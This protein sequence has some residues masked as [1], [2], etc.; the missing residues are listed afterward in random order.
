MIEVKKPVISVENAIKIYRRGKIDVPALRGLT[1]SFRAGD[2]NVIMGPSG[3]GKTTLMNSIAGITKLN[4][5]SIH[6]KDNNIQEFTESQMDHY[7]TNDIGYIFQDNNLFPNLTAYENILL[8]IYISNRN[9]KEKIA[10]IAELLQRLHMT[11]RVHHYPDELSGGEE[12]RIS[13]IMALANNPAILLCDEPTGELDS[14]AKQDVLDLLMQIREFYPEKCIII[15]TH[16]ESIKTIADQLLYIKDG[17][18]SHTLYDTEIKELSRPESQQLT[19]ISNAEK[20]QHTLEEMLHIRYYLETQ[21][22]KLKDQ[23]R[24][25]KF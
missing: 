5:G 13:I 24:Q 25:E 12:Q 19:H 14:K 7:R 3:C 16:D 8:P 6:F 23:I 4:S 20:Y 11:E 10:Y 17:N 15:V 18:I 1:C 22:E 21:I 9:I 2:I